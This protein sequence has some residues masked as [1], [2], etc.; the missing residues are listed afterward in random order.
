MSPRFTLL[1]LMIA[2]TLAG[3]A[4]AADSDSE[5]VNINGSVSKI[6]TL[7]A[8][9]PASVD[10]GEMI[11][12]S[13][14]EVGQLADLG[15]REIELPN[16]FCNYAGTKLTVTGAA[17]LADDTST[18]P[19]DFARAVNFRSTVAGWAS[20]PAQVT[21]A[22]TAAGANPTATADGGVVGKPRISDLTVTLS[23]FT[24]PGDNLL[25]AGGYQG[26]VSVTLGPD[27][28]PN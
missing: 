22:A 8:P 21:T 23:D 4:L 9:T 10:L 27:M 5:Q 2:A 28:E 17:L 24:A 7:G 18:P 19:A 12:T 11:N 6:C 1:P 25:V 16:S 3:P 20:T 15:D 14:A 13:G 26:S